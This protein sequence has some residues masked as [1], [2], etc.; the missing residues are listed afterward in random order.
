MGEAEGAIPN[1]H[2]GTHFIGTP[3]TIGT[4]PVGKSLTVKFAAQI[5]S[6]MPL[7][8]T[9]V[10]NQGT[11][12]GDNFSDVLTD[13][14]SVGGST[15][16]TVTPLELNEAPVNTVP[17]A[18]SATE[19]ANKVISGISVS[20]ADAGTANIT[21]T[22]GVTNGTLTLK[23]D[24][25]NGLVAGEI[26]NNGTNS[27]TATASL[28]KINATLADANG[29]TYVPTASFNGAATLTVTT[30]D[31]GNTGGGGAQQDIDNVTINVA[32]VND[33]PAGANKTVT[34]LEDTAYTFTAADFGFTD[35]NDS[36]A[37]TLLAVK[38]TTLPGAGTLA[39]NS[40]AVNAGD[41]VSVADINAGNLK[42][43]PALNGNGAGYASFTF[44][45]Q[46]DGSTANG[47][48]NLDASANTMTVDVTAVND[49]PSFTK[50]AD[51][52]VFD[53][54]GAQTINNWASNLS[55]GP[56][57]EAGQVLD[58]IVSNDM[59]G[60]FDAQPAIDANGTL[61]FTPKLDQSGTATVTV[62]IHDNGGTANSGDD[63]SDAQTFT[64]TVNLSNATPV[65]DDGTE[66]TNEDTAKTITL[67]ASDADMDALTYTITV[68]PTKGT[69]TNA[70]DSAIVG[71]Q[72]STNQVK[73]T[74]NANYHGSDSFKFQVNDGNIDSNEATVSITVDPIADTPSVTDATTDEDTQ[75]TSGL[76]ISRNA[77]DDAEVTH[78]KITGITN[79]T[80]F[81]NDGTTAINN[82]DFITFAEGN[83]GLKF[84]PSANFSGNGSFTVQAATGNTGADLGGGTATATI[85]VNTVADTPSVTNA[86]TDE[87]TQTTSGLVISRNANDGAEVTHFKITSITNGTLF[88]NDGTTAI[89]SGD[90][91]TFAQ[92]NAGLKFMPNANYYGTGSFDVQASLS[93]TDTGLGG[94]TATATITV[95]PVAD[96]PSVTNATTNEDTQTTSGLVISPNANDS[97]E[98]THFKITAITNGTL[99]QNDGTT[100]INNG[101]FITDIEGFAGLKFTPSANFS[102]NGS[103]V[104]QASTSDGNDGLGGST[105]TATITVNSR[106]D[107]PILDDSGFVAATVHGQGSSIADILFY[108]SLGDAIITDADGD[109]EGIAITQVLT[110]N[111]SWQYSLNGG[112]SWLALGAVSASNARLLKSNGNTTRLRFLPKGAGGANYPNQLTFRAWDRTSGIEGAFANTTLN[113]GATAFSSATESLNVLVPNDSA[114]PQ[115]N[116]NT[117]ASNAVLKQMPAQ[118]LGTASDVG[119]VSSGIRSVTVRLYRN[120]NPI[121]G[122]AAG[123]WNGNVANPQFNATY[124][125]AAHERPVALTN[126][127]ANWNLA[128][129]PRSGSYFLIATAID[130]VGKKTALSRSFSVN[131]GSPQVNIVQPVSSRRYKSS[132]LPLATGT[133]YDD[134][135]IVHVGVRLYRYANATTGTPEGFWNGSSANPQF[136]PVYNPAMHERPT[137][138]NGANWSLALPTL[139]AARYA[140]TATAYDGANNSN[141]F[142]HSFYITDGTPRVAITSPQAGVSYP[143][144]SGAGSLTAVTG[145][146]SDTN[147][148]GAP[149]GDGIVGVT[150][151]L[152]RKASFGNSE[153]Y[154]NGTAFTMPYNPVVHDR[155]ASNTASGGAPAFS[156]WS[157]SLPAL[158]VGDYSV[159]A[160]AYDSL[161]NSSHASTGVQART[162]AQSAAP[163]QTAPDASVSFTIVAA[164]TV[165][166][167]KLSGAEAISSANSITLAF[168]GTAPQGQFSV[169][170]NGQ[171]VKVSDVIRSA[172]SLTLLLSDGSLQAGDEVQVAWAGGNTSLIAK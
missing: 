89:S 171:A 79:G 17:G 46:D 81:Q 162:T 104:V 80:L 32:A 169:K 44:Q 123:Y 24:V 164:P 138:L 12:S 161:G 16:K 96:T 1:L 27:V 67:G 109:P 42:F 13:D 74:P 110:T 40:V 114:P 25:T 121:T 105:A 78:F 100:P 34:T 45:V 143:A 71:N 128:L 94:G 90:F 10:E 11:V 117:P 47:G 98:V 50:G 124:N 70:D 106:N 69:L 38:I 85:T 83:A 18:Q 68:S 118:A 154:W 132:E 22:L 170:V 126:G 142:T 168:A 116:I 156:T 95:D 52:T 19:D 108:S 153:G 21:V 6:I 4:L 152:H 87:D 145:T 2:Q 119:L 155:A 5:T 88:Q 136:A 30:N 144:G 53:D 61:T 49:E 150:V 73:Y 107:A 58:F 39:N 84:T 15:D 26:T 163:T 62:Q 37:N 75:T 127:Y 3:I 57:N 20:D 115:V 86:T 148:A 122:T 92:G 112:Q 137:T 9:Q 147:A 36:P 151:R 93:N 33:E 31:N 77:N 72:P 102:G 23:T 135:A 29:L 120:A 28:S 130:G 149:N 51:Q 65:A 139:A 160:S 7:A 131:D 141:F 63:T 60:L 14:P 140:L 125:A 172:S 101:D 41:S 76:V 157:R 111:G 59:N 158:N 134:D 97:S 129:P 43:T 82:N 146:T 113:G 54:A 159:V 48:A 166:E 56:A 8:A 66:S 103:F 99:Y 55:A 91:I 167:S 35:P 64:I 133:A 165:S